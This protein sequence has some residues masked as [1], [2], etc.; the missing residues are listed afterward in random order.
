MD[1]LILLA[2]SAEDAASSGAE[3]ASFIFM[4]VAGIALVISKLK[5]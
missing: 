1:L 4:V 3:S 2:E 5:K